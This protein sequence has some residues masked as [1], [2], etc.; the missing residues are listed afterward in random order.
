MGGG[1]VDQQAFYSKY[2][3]TEKTLKESGLSWSSLEDIYADY[4]TRKKDLE[5]WADYIVKTLMTSEGVHSIRKR[6]KDPEHL[7]EKIVR[8]KLAVTTNNYFDKITDLVGIRVLHLFKGEWKSIHDLIE[9]SYD[10]NEKPFAYIR[11]GDP[12][13]YIDDYKSAGIE[14]RKHDIGYRSIHYVIKSKPA[15]DILYAEIQVRTIFEE[16][17]SEID[18][19]V[20]YP[21]NSNNKMLQEYLTIFNRL[22][23]AADEM[24]SFVKNLKDDSDT[25]TMQEKYI[26]NKKSR[27][28]SAV[29]ECI[30]K[31]SLPV[32]DISNI[33]RLLDDL[34]HLSYT[35]ATKD[36][37]AKQD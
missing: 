4:V 14:H 20:R 22:S 26:L 9:K 18:H 36:A 11:E 23:G 7:I 29:R 15:R 31:S 8:K 12:K 34:D 30:C 25:D 37:I 17:W 1:I 24:G 27:L 6:I 32:G 13:E 2:N 33:N 10:L 35:L 28:V 19:L 3:I 5:N 16:G 21:S